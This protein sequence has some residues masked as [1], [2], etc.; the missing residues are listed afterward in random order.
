MFWVERWDYPRGYAVLDHQEFGTLLI[1][2]S[3]FSPIYRITAVLS[4]DL[5]WKLDQRVARVRLA[6]LGN[7]WPGCWTIYHP[8]FIRQ[9][10]CRSCFYLRVGNL[11]RTLICKP[12]TRV[13]PWY[14][15]SREAGRICNFRRI[16]NNSQ[17]QMEFSWRHLQMKKVWDTNHFSQGMMKWW[18]NK[19]VVSSM[20]CKFTPRRMRAV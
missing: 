11:T 17:V 15:F 6:V 14:S 16:L 19:W 7:F 9:V 18:Y 2:T 8:T 1:W 20:F 10:S 12:S 5:K 3:I 13:S 4:I